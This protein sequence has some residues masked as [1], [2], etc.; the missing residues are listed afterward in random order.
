[1]PPTNGILSFIDSTIS[2]GLD[3]V[4]FNNSIKSFNFPGGIPLSSPYIFV[5]KQDDS[6]AEISLHG[7][8]AP[9]TLCYDGSK[10]SKTFL[11]ID[12]IIYFLT[13]IVLK[14]FGCKER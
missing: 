13:I 14:A 10:F 11:I 9:Q 5:K 4:K 12:T 7:M 3:L 2:W 1:M 8:L 6:C